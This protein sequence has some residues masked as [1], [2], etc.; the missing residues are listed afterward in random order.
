HNAHFF[1]APISPPPSLTP[2]PQPSPPPLSL[3]LSPNPLPHTSPHLSPPPACP[4][5]L[6]PPSPLPAFPHLSPTLRTPHPYPSLP[7]LSP[8]PLAQPAP[9]PLFPHASRL[10]LPSTPPSN[11][12]PS[13]ALA[14]RLSPTV[15]LPHALILPGGV[16]WRGGSGIQWLAQVNVRADHGHRAMG[17]RRGGEWGEDKAVPVR[18]QIRER[19]WQCALPVISLHLRGLPSLSFPSLSYFPFPIFLSLL[20][21]PSLAFL[22]SPPSFPS[23]RSL[24]S[25]PYLL[26]LFA[27]PIQQAQAKMTT[28][29]TSPSGHLAFSLAGSVLRLL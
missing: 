23:L 14:T 24:P 22:H 12:S 11:T 8:K 5:G 4:N 2:L 20:S 6:Y 27:G 16:S 7:R 21:L 25:P 17:H 28:I 3:T 10:C 9:Q 18:W 15:F 19:V 1:S 13:H 29:I 26:S